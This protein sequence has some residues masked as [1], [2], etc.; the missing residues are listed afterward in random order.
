MSKHKKLPKVLLVGRTNVGKSTL[1]NRL[2]SDKRSI[3]FDQEGV[4]R[5]YIEET[6]TWKDTTFNLI[7]TGGITP[8]KIK[9]ELWQKS[10][11]QVHA[12]LDQA[13][14]LV[15]VVDGKNGLTD[16]DRALCK[17]FHKTQKP[18]VLIINKADCQN[19]L[20]ET[21]GDFYTLGI[22]DILTISSLHGTGIAQLLDYI[23]E[24]L[25]I[26]N[27]PII[28]DPAHR[29]TIIGKP[30]VGKSSLMNLLVDH[31]RSIVSNI[32]GTTREAVSQNLFYCSDLIKLTDTAG[33][34]KSA[35]INDDLETLMVQSSF[36]AVKEADTIIIMIDASQGAISDQELKLLFY[37]FEHKK[38]MLVVM[39]KIDLQ[40]DYHKQLLE[41]SL[42]EY[43]FILSKVSIINTSCLTQKNIGR[44]F[45]EIQKIWTR[46]AQT[47]DPEK[48]KAIVQDQLTRKVLMHNGVALTVTSIRQIK[49]PIPTFMIKVNKPQFFGP[50]EQNCIENILRKTFDLKGCPVQF[51]LKRD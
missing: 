16:E 5:D 17:L 40:T 31:E 13:A 33:V 36:H 48:L 51:N 45:H 49:A 8:K 4:T 44:I 42:E 32:A 23:V 46:S 27:G 47:F 14:L 9:D 37:V 26:N 2:V 20:A 22:K 34:R 24:S 21:M 1:F 43:A 10:Q 50:A 35:R 28:N 25:N 18:L 29:I 19:A 15:F 38:H 6:M 3:V 30:N 41:K 11:A 39:N 7:D 12:L